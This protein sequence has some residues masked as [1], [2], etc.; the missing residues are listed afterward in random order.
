MRKKL[1]N[2]IIVYDYAFVNGGAAR[3]AIQSAIALSNID[4]INV[5]FFSAVGP[6]CDELQNSSVNCKCLNISDIN[7]GNRIK[8]MKNG[9]WNSGAKQAFESLL[10][11]YDANDTVI[12][13]HGWSKALSSVVINRAIKANFRCI[14]TLHDYFTVCPNGGLYNYSTGKICKIVP[15]SM[16]CYLCNCDKRSYPQKIWRDIRQ[17]VQNC[18]VK[19]CSQLSYISISDLNERVVK[20]FVQSANFYRVDNPTMVS[21]N[22][23][24]S[25]GATILYVGRLS[26]EKGAELFCQ[27]ICQLKHINEHCVDGVIIGT[28]TLYEELYSKYQKCVKFVGWKNATE[29]QQYMENARAL[30]LPSKWYEGAPLTIIEALMKGLP[31]IVSDCTSAVE[32]IH[33]DVNGFVFK[34]GDVNSLAEKIEKILDDNVYSRFVNNIK[35]QFKPENYHMAMHIDRL[36]KVYEDCLTK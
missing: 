3:V 11:E 16:K 10:K 25:L 20:P 28:G 24:T 5:T 4:E 32:L 23:H 18:V 8:A 15:S 21:A 31:C 7:S 34:S 14:I 6:V 19:N 17:I 27:S 12:H 26:E 36:M 35:E 13:F 29:V 30:V 9:I 22:K 1:R 33:D 2:V